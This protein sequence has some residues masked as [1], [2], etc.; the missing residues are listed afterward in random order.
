[1]KFAT[2][3]KMGISSENILRFVNKLEDSRLSTHDIIIMRGGKIVYEA[4]WKPFNKDFQHRMYSV[5]KSFVAIAIGFLE[6]EG[7]LSLDDKISKYFP[8]ELKNQTD[9]NM[10][11]QTIRHMLMMST[12]KTERSWFTARTDDR[13]RFYFEN[14]KP[15]NSRPSGTI[16]QYD[17]TGSFILGA[18]VERLS[19]MTLIDYLRD[20]LFDKIGVS[21]EATC[22]KCPGGHSWGDSALIC[23]PRDLL[24]VAKFMM[25]GGKWNGEQILN[26]EFVTAATSKQ[27]DNSILNDVEYNSFGYGYQIWRTFDNSFFFN[28]MGCQFAV[29]IPDKDMIFIYNADNQGKDYAKK[30]IFDNFY[31][32]IARTA[33]DLPLPENEKAQKELA[34]YTASLKLAHAIGEKTSPTADRINNKTFVMNDNPMGISK[35][36]LSFNGDGGTFYYTN[37]QGDKE[38]PFGM[39]RNEFVPFPQD[40]YSDI[41]GS[42]KGAERYNCAC[43][44]AWVMPETLI[45]KV[46]IIDKYFGVLNI[47][48]GFIDNK[49]GIQMVKT[50]EDFL[51]E[52]TGFAGGKIENR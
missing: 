51:D 17:S 26:K 31:D 13:V 9:E 22:L 25:D 1:M 48:L 11:N 23:L 16:Y 14:D 24:L 18:L 2:P 12:S 15:K 29:C 28:G 35:I 36:R 49:I 33:Q 4:Y 5:T 7:K 30:I 47:K 38:L 37:E 39:C 6:Q 52:Y 10:H 45:I 42:Q 21:K 43:S 34:E 3:E 40:G 20:R 32:L 46:Q 27:V 8:D 44:T 41:V 19:E 50:A